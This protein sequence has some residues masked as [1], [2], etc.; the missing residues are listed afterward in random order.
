MPI[1]HVKTSP[2]ADVGDPTLIMPSDW[3]SVHAYTLQDAVS[4]G[5][6]TAGALALISS[7]TLFLAGGNNV[8]LSQ[9]GNSVTLSGANTVAQTVQTQNVH[10]VTL[11]GNTAGALALISSG[12]WTLAGGNNVT[13]S[14]NGNAVTISG[15]TTTQSIQTQNVWDLTISGNT[16]GAGALISSGTLTLIGS[17][18]IT[19]SQNGN[20][21]A[22]IGAAGGTGGGS[23]SVQ[24]QNM[25]ALTLSGNT[26]GV[27]ALMSSGT[28]TLAG[29]NN[30]TL[31]QN[32]N[33]VT[34]SAASQT[35]Q[36][37]NRFNVT[38]SGNT[39][40]VMAQVSSGTLTWAGGN[41]ITLSQ[42]GNAI[43]VSGP[44]TVA[45][46]VQTQ[47]LHNVTLSGNTAGAMAQ[48]SSGTLTLAGGNNITLS[49]AGNA[50]TISGPNTVAQSVQTQNVWDLTISGNTAGA[51]ALISS[52]T[53]SLA[54]G[55]NIT[56]SQAGNAISIVGPSPGGGAGFTAGISTQGN[57][58]GTTGLVTGQLL[59]VGGDN[60]TLSQ[61]VN[62]GS[63]S[64]TISAA[65]G[66]GAGSYPYFQPSDGVS[67]NAT[68]NLSLS[69]SRVFLV[70]MLVP[71]NMT[72]SRFVMLNSMP[73]TSQVTS[74]SS[75]TT[76]GFLV[77][78]GVALYRYDGT[79]LSMASSNSQA[80]S[81]TWTSNGVSS[82]FGGIRLFSMPLNATLLPG[83]WWAAFSWSTAISR[84]NSTGGTATTVMNNSFYYGA[85]ASQMTGVSGFHGAAADANV[86]IYPFQGAYSVATN[87]F[88]S[89]IGSG[90]I[91][92]AASQNLWIRLDGAIN[93]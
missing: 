13:L 7:G 26:A 33:A 57:T 30:V 87:S 45:Q 16:A 54:G 52:G 4:L 3:N 67:S 44:N 66:A 71:N 89:T 76:F 18:N 80:T 75:N 6:N 19:L 82:L 48:I 11:A 59:L 83:N 10:N 56:L 51:G 20:S 62:A 55:A 37:Q 23:Q 1:N 91:S 22:I 47:N 60:I 25:V 2:Q 21:I 72:M 34:I 17:D 88:P 49:Q 61:S 78:R 77:S 58:S 81:W 85:M 28:V 24:T 14:Q 70:H 64:L 42:N 15:A 29:G 43:T 36:T 8:T 69:A 5:G 12:T 93:G 9:N 65:A 79:N 63:A 50:V 41:N 40:G 73:G 32:G 35:V 46:T 53:L 68:A 90:D 92:T 84:T 31:S 86:E 74:A 39:A 38:L 27:L